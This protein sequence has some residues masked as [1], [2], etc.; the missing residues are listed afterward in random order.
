M[1]L[2]SFHQLF[3]QTVMFC[4]II[5]N[6]VKLIYAAMKPGDLNQNLL[7]VDKWTLGNT[8]H[9]L[10]ELDYSDGKPY[11]SNNDYEFLLHIT[12]IRNHYCHEVYLKFIYQDRILTS[13][14]FL[15]EYNR[16]KSDNAKLYTVFQTMERVRVKAMRDYNRIK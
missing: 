8:V 15:N 13:T 9:N 2:D 12:G 3:G 6:D 14:Q 4:Q 11:L 10:R 1:T 16:L 5:E 7:E